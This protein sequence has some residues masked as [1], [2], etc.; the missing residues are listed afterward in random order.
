VLSTEPIT[1]PSFDETSEF[2]LSV[3]VVDMRSLAAARNHCEG[4]VYAVM[5]S[6]KYRMKMSGYDLVLE[7]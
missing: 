6:S 5:S 4:S 1:A 2:A 3:A 7:T